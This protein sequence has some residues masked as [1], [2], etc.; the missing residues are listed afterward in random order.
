MWILLHT[1]TFYY[2]KSFLLLWPIVR[3]KKV[4]F[5]PLY[6]FKPSTKAFFKQGKDNYPLEKHQQSSVIF[7]NTSASLFYFKAPLAWNTVTR[8]HIPKVITNKN[9][10]L[11]KYEIHLNNYFGNM[12]EAVKRFLHIWTCFVRIVNKNDLFF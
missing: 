11:Y 5:F 7:N 10:V 3:T 9:S 12:S 6:L 4:F 2:F 1:S 8:R